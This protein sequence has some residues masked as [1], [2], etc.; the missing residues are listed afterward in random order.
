MTSQKIVEA[1]ID[2]LEAHENLSPYP[3]LHEL[4]IEL[5]LLQQRLHH[6]LHRRTHN[7]SCVTDIVTRDEIEYIVDYRY[8]PARSAPPAFSHDDVNFSIPPTC[9][10]LEVLKIFSHDNLRDVL[11]GGIFVGIAEQLLRRERN[12]RQNP[13][14]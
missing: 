5:H 11:D 7:H 1:A 4:L 13:C 14:E 10:E 8:T 12:T 2:L 9:E 3:G 6:R